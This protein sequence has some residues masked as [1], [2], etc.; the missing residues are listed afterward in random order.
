M[1]NFNLMY[2]LIFSEDKNHL[3]YLLNKYRISIDE[4]KYC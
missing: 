4:S 2:L 3:K 1:T